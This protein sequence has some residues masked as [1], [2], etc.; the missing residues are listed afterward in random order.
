MNSHVA[1]L[2][3]L[4]LTVFLFILWLYLGINFITFY[5]HYSSISTAIYLIF[6]GAVFN[7]PLKIRYSI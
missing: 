6:R 2:W 5:Q 4:A 3:F 1:L 7:I